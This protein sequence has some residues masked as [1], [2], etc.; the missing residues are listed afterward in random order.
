M[1]TDQKPGGVPSVL[2]AQAKPLRGKLVTPDVRGHFSFCIHAQPHRAVRVRGLS[3][4]LRHRCS[5]PFVGSEKIR[6]KSVQN[7]HSRQCEFSIPVTP[8]TYNFNGLKCTG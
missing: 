2:Q 6:T 5:Y 4:A 7:D 8:T 1:K 3:L